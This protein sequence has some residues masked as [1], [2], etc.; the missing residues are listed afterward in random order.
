LQISAP[1]PSAETVRKL[2]DHIQKF[3]DRVQKAAVVL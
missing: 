2:R 1:R 3:A